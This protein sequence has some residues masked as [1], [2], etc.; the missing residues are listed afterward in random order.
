VRFVALNGFD[1]TEEN[2][3]RVGKAQRAL[4]RAHKHR[5]AL[6][7]LLANADR[8]RDW[9][10]DWAERQLQRDRFYIYSDAE[11]A[12]LAEEMD[13]LQPHA[14]FAGYS[15]DELIDTAAAFSA[16]CDLPDEEFLDRLCAERPSELPRWQLLRLVRICRHVAGLDLP[17]QED[18]EAA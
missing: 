2:V 7:R 6:E 4:D 12:V 15:I 18:L 11:H 17:F 3:A 9:F 5:E 14:G 10:R 8:L 1:S 16:D 13:R